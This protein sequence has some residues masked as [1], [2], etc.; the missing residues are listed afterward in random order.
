MKNSVFNKDNNNIYPCC[1]W[2]KFRFLVKLN[3]LSEKYL[4]ETEEFLVILSLC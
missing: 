1:Y 2:E 4:N 3:R